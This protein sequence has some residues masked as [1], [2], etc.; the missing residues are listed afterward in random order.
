MT[1]N[2]EQL[3]REALIR[4]MDTYLRGDSQEATAIIKDAR[5]AVITLTPPA[6]Q[7]QAQQPSTVRA[8]QSG[9]PKSDRQTVLSIS[10]AVRVCPYKDAECGDR[11]A[12]WCDTCPKRKQQPSGGEVKAAPVES[13]PAQDQAFHAFWYS[14]MLDDLMQP[15]L[16]GISHSTARYIW[17]SA[18]ATKP[19]PMSRDDLKVLMSESGYVHVTAQEKA[20][21]INGFRHA[22]AHHGI[23]STITST[24]EPQR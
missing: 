8:C 23:T 1:T 13:Y 12:N 16:A 24:K 18:L 22:E 7:E 19:E 14:H 15:P 5:S 17:D 6:S 3:L 21:F 2:T 10:D 20:D 9:S 11:P 4:R